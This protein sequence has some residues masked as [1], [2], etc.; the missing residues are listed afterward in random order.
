MVKANLGSKID[1]Y[2]LARKI[3]EQDNILRRR[4]NV[5][6]IDGTSRRACA[7]RSD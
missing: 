4:A 2:Y 7:G 6:L 1:W 3:R 5:N